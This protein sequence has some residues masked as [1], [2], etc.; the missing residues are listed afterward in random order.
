MKHSSYYS[1]LDL[2]TSVYINTFLK[3]LFIYA[4][5]CTRPLLVLRLFL[6]LQQVGATLQLHELQKP[7]PTGS[8]FIYSFQALEHQLSSCGTWAQLLHSMQILPGEG[9]NLCLLHWQADSLP[10]RHQESQYTYIYTHIHTYI[11]TYT[12]TPSSV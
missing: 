2:Q 9:S 12:H 11:Y 8:V 5:V 3:I 7:Q 10:L 4:S 1:P 6:Q